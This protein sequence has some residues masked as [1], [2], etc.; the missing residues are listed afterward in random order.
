MI[1]LRRKEVDEEHSVKLVAY[2]IILFISSFFVP[3]VIVASYQSMVYFSRS[4]WFFSTPFSA[5]I[6][7]MGGMLFIAVILTVYL[8]LRQ[9][10]EG[11]RLKW[12]TGILILST[13]PAFILSLTNYYYMDD[14]GIHY[15]GLTGLG[16]KEYKW[17][18]MTNV[19]IVYRN[20]QGTT[21]LFQYKFEMTDGSKITLPFNDKLSANKY[22]V[23][24]KVKEYKI[25]VKDNFKNP[26]VD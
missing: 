7:F 6:T 1:L 23:E 18:E 13:I 21:G 17:D 19:H 9:R 8:I 10:R 15:N 24:Q 16:E 4:Y 11:I 22:K 2:T 14:D 20:H 5:Y 25:T 26:I 3:F 12:I